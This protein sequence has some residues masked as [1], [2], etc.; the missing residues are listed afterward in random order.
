M[1]INFRVQIF[2][3]VFGLVAIALVGGF[4]KYFLPDATTG[5]L[6]G[7]A[8]TTMNLFVCLERRNIE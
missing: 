5:C 7:F 1:I 6:L 2:R 8:L 3:Y 4:A